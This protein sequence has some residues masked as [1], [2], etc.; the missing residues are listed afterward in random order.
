MI[1]YKDGTKMGPFR[2]FMVNTMGQI[3]CRVE[4]LNLGFTWIDFIHDDSVDYKKYL[5]P[6]WKPSFDGA[7]T[8]ISNHS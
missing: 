6:D 1:G 4:L 8:M 3:F 2:N 7:T 5:G